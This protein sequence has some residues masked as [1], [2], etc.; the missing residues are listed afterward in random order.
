MVDI[1]KMKTVYIKY[2]NGSVVKAEVRDNDNQSFGGELTTPAEYKKYSK[3]QEEIN[4]EIFT[5][6]R[7]Y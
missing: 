4:P 7:K 3:G 5:A 1:M 2:D 6:S